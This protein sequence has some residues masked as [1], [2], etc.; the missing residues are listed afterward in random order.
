MPDVKLPGFR[1]LDLTL[2]EKADAIYGPQ[3][4]TD[5]SC[6]LIAG[7]QVSG[8]SIAAQDRKKSTATTFLVA[9]SIPTEY[10]CCADCGAC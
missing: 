8:S 3:K 2:V 1:G 4:T 10:L 9:N 7:M 5:A 6:L